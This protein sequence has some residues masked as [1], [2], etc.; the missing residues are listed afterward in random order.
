MTNGYAL[1]AATPKSAT[2]AAAPAAAPR[3]HERSPW[4]ALPLTESDLAAG[5]ISGVISGAA[6]MLT[7]VAALSV[8]V[9]AVLITRSRSK[10][11][12]HTK[13]AYQEVIAD[14]LGLVGVMAAALWQAP[15]AGSA[16]GSTVIA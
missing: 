5:A 14:K 2:V 6:H 16:P 13:G 11:S 1:G 7:D 8:T 15:P 9:A 4:R 3:A 10:K 12:V